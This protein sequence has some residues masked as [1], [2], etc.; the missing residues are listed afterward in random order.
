MDWVNRKQ[1]NQERNEN[2]VPDFYEDIEADDVWKV[3]TAYIN[4]GTQPF[5]HMYRL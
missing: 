5:F 1:V 4:P 2:F 3:Y